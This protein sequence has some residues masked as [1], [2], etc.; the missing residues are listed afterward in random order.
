MPRTAEDVENFLYRLD[1]NFE[2]EGGMFLVSSGTDGPP[3]A[4]RVVEPIVVVRVDI[5]TIPEDGGKQQ[6]MMRKLLEYNGSDLVHAAYALEGEQ[7]VLSAGLELEGLDENELAAVLSDIDLALARH[8]ATL[9]EL[10]S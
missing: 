7:I 4:V 10:A 8:V 6:L 9:H 2:G 1:R 5:G 3:I